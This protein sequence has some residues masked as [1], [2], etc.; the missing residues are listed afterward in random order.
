MAASRNDIKQLT[1]G[2]ED[3]HAPPAIEADG[4]PAGTDSGRC[5]RASA[6]NVLDSRYGLAGPVPPVV[7]GAAWCLRLRLDFNQE[8]PEG[9]A[10]SRRAT[11]VAQA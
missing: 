9:H 3:P 2:P 1:G 7:G 10:E 11:M 5:R 6:N 8:F 4:S